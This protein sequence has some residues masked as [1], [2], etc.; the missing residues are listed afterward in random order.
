MIQKRKERAAALEKCTIPELSK[1]KWR[2][3]MTNDFMSSEESE[4]GDCEDSSS[5]SNGTHS[6]SRVLRT[7]PL[8]YRSEKVDSFFKKLAT[9]TKQQKSTSVGTRLYIPRRIGSTSER[10]LPDGHNYPA[11]AINS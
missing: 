8:S 2:K 3:V 5:G 9:L 7:R 10:T 6:V 1:A 11:W 4:D